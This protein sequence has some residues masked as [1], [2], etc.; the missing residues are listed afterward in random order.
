K[1]VGFRL[2]Y[3]K[4]FKDKPEAASTFFSLRLINV[5]EGKKFEVDQKPVDPQYS[6]RWESEK[7]GVLLACRA[8]TRV[9][10]IE[11]PPEAARVMS[12]VHKETSG[13][14]FDTDYYTVA[15][16]EAG[17]FDTAEWIKHALHVI[18]RDSSYIFG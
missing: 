3:F 5:P 7:K 6:L 2:V 11:P 17:Q 18:A 9:V 13:I 14:V 10:D 1:R 15:P 8:E 12:P 4:E 16:V